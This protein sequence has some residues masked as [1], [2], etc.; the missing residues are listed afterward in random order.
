MR[1]QETTGT[2]GS[3]TTLSR[4]HIT[5]KRPLR[6]LIGRDVLHRQATGTKPLLCYDGMSARS[7]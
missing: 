3:D 1:S 6:R 4:A 7:G 2:R 5:F